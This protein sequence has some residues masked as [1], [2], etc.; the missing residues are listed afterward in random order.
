L[1]LGADSK[2]RVCWPVPVQRLSGARDEYG[3]LPLQDSVQSSRRPSRSPKDSSFTGEGVWLVFSTSGT[4]K[5]SYLGSWFPSRQDHVRFLDVSADQTKFNI[6]NSTWRRISIQPHL[7]V[8]AY[9][10]AKQRPR[11]WCQPG[12][13]ALVLDSKR[14]THVCVPACS[15]YSYRLD[16]K[17]AR[18]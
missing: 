16:L 11:K 4:A 14:S 13:R 12:N 2:G 8:C 15:R 6:V 18:R 9:Q 10:K 17:V 3:T 5:S 7:R 1:R